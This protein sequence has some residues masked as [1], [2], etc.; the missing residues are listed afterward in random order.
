M[1]KVTE[2]PFNVR[3][4]QIVPEPDEAGRVL[5]LT[6][7]NLLSLKSTDGV[8]S[9][10][11]VVKNLLNGKVG[12]EAALSLVEY[13]PAE[14]RYRVVHTFTADLGLTQENAKVAYD[15]AGE[16]WLVTDGKKV[17]EVVW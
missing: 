11:D 15:G 12:A 14:N 3:F 13:T 5:F 6:T 16:R 7:A 10:L 4:N 8:P 9:T 1:A 2:W 17:W